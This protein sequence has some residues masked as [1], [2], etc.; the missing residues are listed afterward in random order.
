MASK[1]IYDAIIYGATGFTGR[2]VV[3][4]FASVQRNNKN[5][6]LKWAIAGRTPAKLNQVLQNISKVTGSICVY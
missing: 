5:K 3:R 2:Y 1:R 6:A 4:E